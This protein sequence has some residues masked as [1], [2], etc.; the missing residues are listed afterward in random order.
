MVLND[1][2]RKKLIAT[3][4]DV[5]R[6]F[7]IAAWAVRKH[8]DFVSSFS[9]QA[10]THTDFDDELEA[11]MAWWSDRQNCDVRR[12]HPFRRMI[13]LAEARKIVDGDFFFLKLA[14]DSVRGALQAIEADRVATPQSGPPGF[15]V[16]EW[17]NGIKTYA[18]GATKE[19]AINKRDEY[20]NLQFERIVP[21]ASVF[22]HGCYDRF[23]QIRG[24]SPIAAALNTFQDCYEGFDYALAK[25]K[26]S[27]LFGLVFYRDAEAAFQNT[28]ATMDSDGD[29]IADSGYEVDFGA[30]PVQLDLNPGDKAEFL[31]SRSPATETVEF[32]RLMVHVSLKALDIPFSFFDESFTN[33]FGSR[34]GLIQYTKS[35]KAKVA[36]LQEL[37]NEITKWRI[38]LAI[39]DG[40]LS[41][42]RGM[43]FE[44]LRWEWVPDGTPWWNP[45]QEVKGAT[46]AIAAGL[47]SPQRVCRETGTDFFENIDQIAEAMAYARERGVPLNLATT[48]TTNLDDTVDDSEDTKKKK[49]ED[50]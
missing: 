49:N 45:V 41:L 10:R 50:D 30:G 6:N 17:T 32:L 31:E 39:Y 19:Y 9:F 7:A 40:E 14:G 24:V 34:A 16:D 26:V 37:L 29:G 33:F 2:G 46:M 1:G 15:K 35:C 44:D 47:D 3:S 25:L 28:V 38:G 48:G 13:R 18:G 36:D 21:A 12:R 8:L 4:Q 20:G 43:Q 23:D 5:Q 11:Y 22:S 27:Q 42:P